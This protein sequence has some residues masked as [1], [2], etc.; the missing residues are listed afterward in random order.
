MQNPGIADPDKVSVLIDGKEFTGWHTIDIHLQMDS[1][2]TVDFTAPFEPENADF[3]ETFRPFTYKRLEVN[4]G[5]ARLFT[6][7]IVS[8]NPQQDP[9]RS[10]VEVSAYA[11]PGVLADC[12]AAARETPQVF[13]T[14]E[15]TA[16]QLQEQSKADAPLMFLNLGL[17]DIVHALLRPYGLD[18]VFA[19]PE[20]A[21][22][23][24]VKIDVDAT[25]Y[26]FIADLARKRNLVVSNTA[27]GD[28]L[29]WRSVGTGNPVARLREGQAPV[30]AVRARFSP[31]E[32]FSEVVGLIP[33][34]KRKRRN[35][36][37]YIVQ[38]PFIPLNVMRPSAFKLDDTEPAD[39]PQAVRARLARM[40]GNVASF[41]V[42]IATWRDPQGDLWRPNT[43]LTLDAPSAMVYREYEFLVRGVALHQDKESSSAT[44]N[45]VLP[46]SFSGEVPREGLPWLEPQ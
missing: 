3:R 44:L 20:G 25:V 9:E 35:G 43:T 21:K 26:G 46:G 10:A 32:Y 6:G 30:V 45:V 40:F 27:D 34:S 42:G 4:V 12:T 36:A 23:D 28:L 5:G 16:K 39:G 33:P 11:L 31:Q 19:S 14:R 1:F 22:F 8:I 17:R 2:S 38:N 29:C 18:V 7:T 15:L 41:D 37:R 24:Q 13:S